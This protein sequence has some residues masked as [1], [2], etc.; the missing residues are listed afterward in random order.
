MPLCDRHANAQRK[1][2]KRLVPDELLAAAEV[3]TRDDRFGGHHKFVQGEGPLCRDDIAV[4]EDDLERKARHYGNLA[5]AYEDLAYWAADI[6]D[7][8]LKRL[9]QGN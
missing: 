2:P 8:E 4:L 1:P 9:D 6:A 7:D 3:V 5:A